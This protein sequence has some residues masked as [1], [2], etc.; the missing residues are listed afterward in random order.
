MTSWREAAG[1]HHTHMH[2]HRALFNFPQIFSGCNFGGTPRPWFSETCTHYIAPSSGSIS[3]FAR[4][5]E[6]MEREGGGG[7]GSIVTQMSSDL[8]ACVCALIW[9]PKVKTNLQLPRWSLLSF[10]SLLFL[11]QQSR[12]RG[13][14]CSRLLFVRSQHPD[15]APHDLPCPTS[16]LLSCPIY[17]AHPFL[18]P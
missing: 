3:T 11:I 12:S 8:L 5:L 9:T 2:I 10:P 15:A 17:C 7:A 16:S 14:N 4:L 6:G 1:S 18:S 13:F